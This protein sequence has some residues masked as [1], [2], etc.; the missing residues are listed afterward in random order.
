MLIMVPLRFGGGRESL[1]DLSRE[2]D[3]RRRG[4]HN[5]RRGGEQWSG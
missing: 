2:W 5:N 4:D 1:I 3:R